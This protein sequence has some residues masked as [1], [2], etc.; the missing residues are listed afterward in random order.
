M[1]RAETAR[2]GR[3]WG[4]TSGGGLKDDPR[5]FYIANNIADQ[6]RCPV[7]ACLLECDKK[8]LAEA[9]TALFAREHPCP[10]L[11]VRLQKIFGYILQL[12]SQK[13]AICLPS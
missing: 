4:S 8:H 10:S 7:R 12:R 3:S 1:C 6:D 11:H 9:P 13:E 5:C 2:F